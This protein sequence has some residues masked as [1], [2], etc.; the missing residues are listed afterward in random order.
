ML[1][2][3]LKKNLKLWEACLPHIEFA[4]NRSLHSTTKMSPFQIVYGF[5]PRAPIDLLPLPSSVKNNFDATQH[6]ELILKLHATTK[7][8]IERMNVK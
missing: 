5:V 2:A 6:V 1:R 4:Y 3:I 7:D 8:F